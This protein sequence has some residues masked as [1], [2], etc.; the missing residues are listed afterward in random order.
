MFQVMQPYSRT[1]AVTSQK[2]F[3]FISSERSD[4]HIIDNS[5]Q[6]VHIFLLCI[7]TLLSVD[8]ILLLRYANWF[9]N[10]RGFLFKVEK[11][12]SR[13]KHMNSVFIVVANINQCSKKINR[14]PL[15]PTT[16]KINL[17]PDREK[18]KNNFS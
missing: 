3:R 16:N 17:Q 8:E 14:T 18:K 12:P 6:V 10:F 4:F 1:D 13:L 2:K 5:S 9:I 11:A 7:L 15:D